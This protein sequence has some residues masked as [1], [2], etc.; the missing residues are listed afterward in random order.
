MLRGIHKA[1]ANWIGR[2]VMGVV[3][4]LI[5]ISFGIWGIGDIFRGFGQS[6]VAKVGSTE[7][8]IEAF[9]Q[10]YQDRLQA[11]SRQLR[12][13]VLPAQARLLGFDRQVLGSVVTD[14][15]LDERA[16]QL[17]LGISDAEIARRVTEDP[18]FRGLNGQ[19]DR[20]RFELLIRQL[21]YNEAR[22]MAE[23]RQLALRR[24]LTTTVSGDVPVPKALLE[25]VNRYQNEQ[26]GIEFVLLTKAQ[27]G[28]IP[29]PGPEVLNKYFEARKV[30]FR[31]P[32]Y[33]KLRLL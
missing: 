7:I 19:F 29:D 27:V 11:L 10:I 24:Q 21:G 8:R 22:F 6:T 30:L 2:A 15:L 18:N 1:S 17:R 20:G 31:A 26:R 32:E 14:A 33:R 5:A 13:P 9:R 25:A 28:D 12:R 3:L 4:G 16:R 23:Q